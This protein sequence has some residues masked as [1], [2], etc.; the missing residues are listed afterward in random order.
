MVTV[1]RAMGASASPDA[2]INVA[3]AGLLPGVLAAGAGG[4]TTMLEALHLRAQGVI[5]TEGTH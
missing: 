5:T 3:L 2:L 4:L 1:G